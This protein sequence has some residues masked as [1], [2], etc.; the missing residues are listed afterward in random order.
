MKRKR[1]EEKIGCEWREREKS[2]RERKRIIENQQCCLGKEGRKEE[3]KE[4]VEIGKGEAAM[5]Y[6]FKWKKGRV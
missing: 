5:F 3:G 6:I 4:M 1:Q 2:P